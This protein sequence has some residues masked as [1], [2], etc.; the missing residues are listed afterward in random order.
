MLFKPHSY[1]EFCTSKIVDEPYVGLF[2][3]MGLGKTVITLT[4]IN[5]LRYNRWAVQRVLVIAPKKVAEATWQAE[6]A[7]WD[8][9]Q[10]L[11]F[12][13]V[14]GSENKR[15]RALV[16]PADI[17]MISRDNIVWLVDYYRNDWPFDMVVIDE[18]SSFKNYNSK[19]F[20]SLKL[21]RSRIRR[22]VELTGTPSP[23]G[24]AD[25][26][27]QVYL[28]D[29]GKRLGRTVSAYREQF[30][31]ED[32]A[33]PGQAYRTYTPQRDAPDR[34]KAVISDI[35]ISLKSE[36]YLNLPDCVTNDIP[37]TLGQSV[38]KAYRTLER[39]LLLEV[40]DQVI[41]AG[42]AAVLNGKLLQ[43]CSGAVYDENGEIATIHDAKIDAL[44]ETV[45]QLCE[46][47]CL[48]FHWFKHEP[49]RIMKA[50]AQ[51]GRRIRQYRGP[52]D[53][54][55]WNAGDV[56]VLLAHPA[57]C[58]YGLNLQQ[59]GHHI[60]WYSLPNWTLELYQQANKRLHRQGQQHPV[61]VHRLLV[62][63]GI[64]CDMAAA[65]ED[66]GDAQEAML[67]ALKARIE[68]VRNDSK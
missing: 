24:L 53:A 66:K 45:E 54:A 50:L 56:D 48:I 64:D 22:I 3:D 21:V 58:G 13:A 4:A 28:L 34:I 44:V 68:K 31:T 20:K 1:Q 14:L 65:L 7:R 19:R 57:S 52:D 40:K 6:A 61:I 10:H 15:I 16:T 11:R 41:T 18:S 37:V 55:A 46:Q 63:G 33:Y 51:K 59:G 25:L 12:S 43:L 67:Q 39:T 49:E 62:Q 29:Q 9:L 32:K 36:D 26:W 27:A 42:T 38:A 47:H 30:F 17:Y 2:L 8:H 35:C 60:I 23:N 5:E